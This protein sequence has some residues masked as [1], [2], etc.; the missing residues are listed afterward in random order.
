MTFIVRTATRDDL[1]IVVSCRIAFLG[2]VRGPDFRPS[3]GFVER[4]RSFIQAEHQAGRLHT[5]IAED[6]A[7][8]V[9]IVSVLLWP[10]PPQPEDGRIIE[11]YI[12]N[13]YVPPAHERRGIGRQLL[14]HCLNSA[15]ELG[16]RKFLL[17]ATDE[18]RSLYDAMGFGPKPDWM[19]LP[20]PP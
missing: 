9:G 5:W 6:R 20:V 15:E 7:D 2:S 18:G 13:L 12:I 19:E 14:E 16:I 3:G 11:A 17:H 1:E 10:R 8:I 4:T